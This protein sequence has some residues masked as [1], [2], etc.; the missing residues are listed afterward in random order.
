[1]QLGENPELGGIYRPYFQGRRIRQARKGPSLSPDYVALLLGL[2]F[3]R[4]DGYD[5]FLRIVCFFSEL[6]DD[7][8]QKTAHFS[9]KIQWPKEMSVVKE[10]ADALIHEV[11]GYWFRDLKYERTDRHIKVTL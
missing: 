11:D 6:R 2:L 3:D 4:E 10:D 7:A 9:K 8:T 1:M 5:T